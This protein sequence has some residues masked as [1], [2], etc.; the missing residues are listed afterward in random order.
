MKSFL[1]RRVL[2][3]LGALSAILILGVLA[4]LTYGTN[5]SSGV[6]GFLVGH[7]LGIMV[8]LVLLGA[9]SG[10][11]V[12]LLMAQESSANKQAA[13]G[14]AEL[15]LTFLSP[16]ER[17]MVEYLARSDGPV[18]QSHLA[19]AL[20]FSVVQVHRVT[21]RLQQKQ[22]ITVERYGKTNKLLLAAELRNALRQ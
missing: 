11:V 4:L 10:V 12:V 9:A 21:G 19:T 8:L 14:T 7:H 3:A 1:A 2:L 22:F 5:A 13:V 15:L 16:S 6:A 18:L 20:R 17:A